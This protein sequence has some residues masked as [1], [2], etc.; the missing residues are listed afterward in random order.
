[1]TTKEL[2]QKKVGIISLGCDKNRVDTEHILGLL[3]QYGFSITN[4][5]E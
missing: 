3:T 2:K 4:N 1:M 5:I